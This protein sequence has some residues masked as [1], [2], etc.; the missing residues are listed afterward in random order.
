MVIKNLTYLLT[1]QKGR[2]NDA[3]AFTTSALYTNLVNMPDQVCMDDTYIIAD[4]AFP[5]IRTVVPS[6]PRSS[7]N[8]RQRIF[9]KMHSSSR[10]VVEHS[11]DALVSRLRT[12]W[13]HLYMINIERMTLIIIK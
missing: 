12:L 10:I 7:A 2:V 8:R 13:K 1:I 6:F 5:V 4:S 9:N 3:R 11:F